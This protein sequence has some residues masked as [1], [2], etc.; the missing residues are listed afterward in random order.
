MIDHFTELHVIM[1]MHMTWIKAESTI[2]NYIMIYDTLLNISTS[3]ELHNKA[4]GKF[5]ICH[6]KY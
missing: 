3:D 2:W 4:Y 1:H 5:H 6:M